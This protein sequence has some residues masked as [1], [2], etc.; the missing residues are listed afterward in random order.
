[1]VLEV[2]LVV[3]LPLLLEAQLEPG[4]EKAFRQVAGLQWVE[5]VSHQ[6]YWE[7]GGGT[8]SRKRWWR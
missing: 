4:P 7:P 3:L 6:P 8:V 1:M 2:V 5:S